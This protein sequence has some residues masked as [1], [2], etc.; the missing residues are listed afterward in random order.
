MNIAFLVQLPK[1]VS[2]GQR[3]RIEHFEPYLEKKGY[4]LSTFPFIDRPT[5]KILY[6]NGFIFRKLLGVLKGFVK[7]FSFL[8]IAHKFD[9]IFLQREASPIGPPFFEWILV[10]IMRK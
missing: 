4:N 7:R 10:T 9:F 1:N 5:Y 3:F 6:R 2:P 8:F